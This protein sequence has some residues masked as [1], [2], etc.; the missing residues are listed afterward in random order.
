VGRVESAVIPVLKGLRQEDHSLGG[1]H[2]RFQSSLG[3]Q[4]LLQET[5]T[6]TKKKKK[7][8]EIYNVINISSESFVSKLKC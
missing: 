7:K 2:I 1:L 8:K 3:Y 6:N 4:I 5:K